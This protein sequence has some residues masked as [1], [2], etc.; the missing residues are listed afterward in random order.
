[1]SLASARGSIV[2]KT[3]DELQAEQTKAGADAAAEFFRALVR[4]NPDVKIRDLNRQGLTTLAV[5]VH[6]AIVLKNAEQAREYGSALIDGRT[7]LG[8]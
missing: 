8:A 1:V 6:S 3:D 7:A 5:L 4:Q 2:S